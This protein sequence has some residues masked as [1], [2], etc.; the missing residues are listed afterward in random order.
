MEQKA[1]AI[2]FVNKF[3]EDFRKTANGSVHIVQRRQEGKDGLT[4][5]GITRSAAI[6]EILSLTYK[7]YCEGPE[8]D[9]GGPGHVWL[10]AKEINGKSVYIKLK[11]RDAKGGG[12]VALCIGFHIAE[13]SVSHP[14][15]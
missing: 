4:Q 1:F 15:K 11:L 12:R 14:L 8:D 5:L 3:L 6:E 9:H 2:A 13:Y 10:F 7:D